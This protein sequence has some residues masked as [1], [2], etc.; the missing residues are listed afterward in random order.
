MPLFPHP[1][2]GVE[3]PPTLLG[4]LGGLREELRTAWQPPQR[5]LVIT[6]GLRWG[7]KR[8]GKGPPSP[9]QSVVPAQP[10]SVTGAE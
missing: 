5:A 9:V 1:Y 7:M 3:T 6:V 10:P 4:L 8:V 2:R